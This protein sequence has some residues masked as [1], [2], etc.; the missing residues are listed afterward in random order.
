MFFK[1]QDI[2]NNLINNFITEAKLLDYIKQDILKQKLRALWAVA[3]K[4]YHCG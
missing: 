3:I 2:N 1:S 4:Q